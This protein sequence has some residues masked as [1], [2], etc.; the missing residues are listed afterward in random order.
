MIEG[1]KTIGPTVSAE[2]AWNVKRLQGRLL[3]VA[4]HDGNAQ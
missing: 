2:D 3:N 1:V 4:A